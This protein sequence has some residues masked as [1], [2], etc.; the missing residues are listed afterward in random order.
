MLLVVDVQRVVHGGVVREQR[1]AVRGSGAERRGGGGVAVL[2]ALL[3]YS[4]EGG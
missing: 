3:K 1:G 2:A 4:P